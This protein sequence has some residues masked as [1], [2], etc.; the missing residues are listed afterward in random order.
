MYSPPREQQRWWETGQY[1][2]CTRAPHPCS[3]YGLV[4]QLDSPLQSGN[5]ASVS[6]STPLVLSALPPRP[7]ASKVIQGQGISAVQGEFRRSPSSPA[8]RSI[9]GFRSWPNCLPRPSGSVGN[10]A[11]EDVGLVVVARSPIQTRVVDVL[12]AGLSAR[13]GGAGAAP[14]GPEVSRRIAHALRPGIG[15]LASRPLLMR[16][17][18]TA[19]SAL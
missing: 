3:R 19:W 17:C 1:I 14:T 5:P 15:N 9:A 13:T 6:G 16:F 4:R 18:R 10:V 7:P 11:G 2:E 12:P 8:P